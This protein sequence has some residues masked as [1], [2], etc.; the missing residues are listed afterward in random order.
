ML[1]QYLIAFREVLE[2]ALIIT[3]VMAYLAR[4]GRKSLTRYVWRGVLSAAAT[5][6]ILGFSVWLVYG[7][8][9]KSIQALFEGVA[10]LVAVVVL[11]SM[12][13]WMATRGKNLKQEVEQRVETIATKGVVLGLGGFA[14]IAVFREG[15]ETVLFL[16][17]FLVTDT[18]ATVAGLF[19]GI[20]TA[21]ALAYGIFR[22]GMKI[23]LRRFFYF[24]SILLVLLA[25]GLAGYGVHELIEYT[26]AAPWGLLG[27]SA[28][29]LNIASDSL[30][31]HKGII[32]SV[33]AVMFGYT[34]KAE[35]ARVMVH[36]M[37]VALVLPLI[38][39]VY[40]KDRGIKRDR[41][42]FPPAEMVTKI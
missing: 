13:Y 3:I 11:S 16:T 38:M 41:T 10:A 34:I 19:L 2:A 33:F 37:Y 29:N 22:A 35:W 30:F 7:T 24:T 32:G 21:L 17:P 9:Q 42:Q 8:L 14:F 23:N 39:R 5:S 36:L 25:G 27:Q 20:F 40:M 26:G 12:I 15:L 18:L 31:H 1:G 6:L 4:T 28:Y